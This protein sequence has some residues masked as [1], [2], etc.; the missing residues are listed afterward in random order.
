MNFTDPRIAMFCANDKLYMCFEDGADCNFS[1]MIFEIGGGV[2]QLEEEI[3]PE[4][5][6]YTMCF[7]DRPLEADYDMNDVVLRA[8]RLN[9]S[10]IQLSVIACGAHDRVALGGIQGKEQWGFNGKEVHELF[11]LDSHSFINTANK[12]QHI[13]PV[14][15]YVEV[16][17]SLRIEDFLK[18]IYIVN[19]NSNRTISIAKKGEPPFA[20]IVPSNFQYP[21]EGQRITEAYLEFLNWAQSVNQSNDWY[22]FGES[23][24]LYPDFFSTNQ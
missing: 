10:R 24:H 6:A 5:E 9:E 16:D 17:K 19:L 11:G 23:R 20:I 3:E 22:L 4:A 7:E 13:Q 8:T 14:S 12:K 15:E 1:D 18:S 21:L 2:L